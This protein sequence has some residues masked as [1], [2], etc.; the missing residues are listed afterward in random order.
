MAAVDVGRAAARTDGGRL[1]RLA[2]KLDAAAAGA[3]GALLAIGG[4]ELDGP[5]GAP[6]T[7]LVP[8][9]LFLVAYAMCLWFVA[10]RPS[11]SR[12]AVWT[13]IGLNLL[14]VADSVVLVA[15][16]W[17]ALT[18]LGT[19]FVLVQAAAVALVADLEF[20]GLRRTR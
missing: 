16:G 19:G 20:M 6:T 17:F 3:L 8:T 9:G 7:F 14:W 12:P 18:A 11:V 10:T 2:L 15:A 4:A 13:V 5:L 1:L